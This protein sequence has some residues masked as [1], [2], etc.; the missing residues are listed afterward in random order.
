M[1]SSAADVRVLLLE[2]FLVAGSRKVQNI[3]HAKQ[4]LPCYGEHPELQPSIKDISYGLS[5]INAASGN[6]C[7]LAMDREEN[8][9]NAGN[10]GGERVLPG[11][12]HLRSLNTKTMLLYVESESLHYI[13]EDY[14][15]N[16]T[17]F[18]SPAARK[19]SSNVCS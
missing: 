5:R 18:I 8:G 19:S 1:T 6:R 4:S 3:G 12:G 2:V 15:R 14:H 13:S 16:G 11:P 10:C 9:F 17:F 7:I